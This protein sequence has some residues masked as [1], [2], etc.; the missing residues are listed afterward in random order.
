MSPDEER[1]VHALEIK[2]IGFVKESRRFYPKRELLAH[3]LGYVGLDN[4]GL[5]GLES[6]FDPQIRGKQGRLIIQRDGRRRELMSRV[7]REPTAGI[8]LELTIDEYLQNIAERELQA[9]VVEYGA[10]GG[11]IV[12]MDPSSGEILALAN[13]PT[14][15]PNIYTRGD[16]SPAPQSRHPGSLRTRFDVQGRDRV[17]RPRRGVDDAGRHD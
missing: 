8:A 9:G 17:S 1:R 10:T 7:E 11:S 16:G 12:V 15:N 3:V 2:G 13:A 14:F 4:V 5:G 6:S